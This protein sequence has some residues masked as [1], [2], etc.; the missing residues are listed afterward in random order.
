MA[1][2]RA[3]PGLLVTEDELKA[4]QVPALAIIGGVDP[5]KDTVDGMA[6]VMANL[7]V[8][9]IDGGDHATALSS[10]KFVENVKAFLDA[11]A[12]APVAGAK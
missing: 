9:V 10:P 1:C 12:T 7:Q 5:F 8:E 6:K 3:I 4:N 11:H 2:L